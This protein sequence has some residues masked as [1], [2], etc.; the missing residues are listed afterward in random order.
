MSHTVTCHTPDCENE[1]IPIS[2]E[3]DY[4]DEDGNPGTVTDVIC[5]PCRQPI[6]SVVRE[7]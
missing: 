2:L 3:L 5:G 4:T 7:S 1:G 6:G